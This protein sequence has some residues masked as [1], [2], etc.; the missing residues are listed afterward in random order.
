MTNQ[1][2]GSPASNNA[3]GTSVTAT[4][5]GSTG[6][7]SIAIGTANSSAN[8]TAIL[9]NGDILVA[10]AVLGYGNDLLL[11]AFNPTTGVPD[12][13]FGSDGFVLTNINNNTA[14]ANAVIVSGSEILVGGYATDSGGVQ[15]QHDG[16]PISGEVLVDAKIT[17]HVRGNR[18]TD[19]LVFQLPARFDRRTNPSALRRT[20]SLASVSERVHRA[21]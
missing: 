18:Q 12:S 5:T 13:S 21:A 16:D 6:S 8:A 4:Y 15:L 9:P 11:E 19:S 7:I 1:Y 3:F 2:T 20:S 14:Q 10:G 17:R